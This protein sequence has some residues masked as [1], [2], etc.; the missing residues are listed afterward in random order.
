MINYEILKNE[1]QCNLKVGSVN[2]QKRMSSLPRKPSPNLPNDQATL[3]M[4][5]FVCLK[6]Q[7]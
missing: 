5:V 7:M 4:Q 3:Y 2:C 1:T 6:E